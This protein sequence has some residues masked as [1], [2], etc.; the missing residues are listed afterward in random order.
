MLRCG[1]NRAALADDMKAGC[2]LR[3]RPDTALALVEAKADWRNLGDGL[4]QARKY[5][6]TLG[7]KLAW[8]GLPV[9][10]AWRCALATVLTAIICGSASAEITL[11]NARVRV[12]LGDDATWRSVVDKAS[13]KDF[14]ALRGKIRFAAGDLGDGGACQVV[15]VASAVP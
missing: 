3:Y 11:E 15:A 1:I 4:E 9:T 6:E 2:A 13:G 5:A 10:R 8:E 7:L 12:V 14:I